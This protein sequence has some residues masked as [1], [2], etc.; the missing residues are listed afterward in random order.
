MIKALYTAASGMGAQQKNLD[1]VASNM[2][3]ANTTG[4]KR[5]R[6]EFQ[7]LIYQT[8]K[9]SAP[10]EQGTTTPV[11]LQIGGGTKAVASVKNFE[12]GAPTETGNPLDMMVRGD[13]FFQVLMP[14]GRISYTRDGSW[15][16]SADGQVVNTDGLTM[17]PPITIPTDATGVQIS[18]EGRVMVTTTGATEPSEIGQI[19][20]ARFVNPAGLSNLGGN[21]YS[22]TV[23]SGDPLVA[24]PGL[25]G[26]GTLEQGFLEASN[27]DIVTEMVSL[28]TAQRAYELNSKS[29]RTADDMISI[30]TQLKR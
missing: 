7:D 11:D 28:I 21:L 9:T 23:A 29:V 16:L 8:M 14:D 20:L 27:V 30:A 17:E 18:A 22:Q 5:S 26:T 12:M 2:A 13:G 1:N 25:D 3:N 24:T 15:K 10:T 19:E 4:F 6:I